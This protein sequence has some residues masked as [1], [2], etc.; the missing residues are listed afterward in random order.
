[1]R[2]CRCTLYAHPCI[3]FCLHHCLS[4]CNVAVSIV[5]MWCG[6]KDS[7]IKN[8]PDPSVTTLVSSPT[9][10][11]LIVLGHNFFISIYLLNLVIFTLIIYL[12]KWLIL[13]YH[14]SPL[15]QVEGGCEYS[16]P[17]YR[18]K[19]AQFWSWHFVVPNVGKKNKYPLGLVISILR[20]L[21]RVHKPYS[22][23]E[24]F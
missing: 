9:G 8:S 18:N 19:F 22:H 13:N 15:S 1:M 24:G 17:K 10:F 7:I 14:W 16:H 6:G 23:Y 11:W 5:R 12:N 2:N 20:H 21:A 3:V 4:R